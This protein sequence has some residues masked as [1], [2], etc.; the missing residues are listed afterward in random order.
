MVRTKGKKACVTAPFQRGCVEVR[1]A[2]QNNLKGV[3]VDLPLGKLTVVTGP[4]GSGKSSLAFETIYAE[5]Q[6]RYVETFSPYMRQFLDRMDKPR[7]DDIRGIPPAIAIE[8][9]NPVKTSRSTVGTMTEINDYLKLLW[10]RIAKA[11]CPNCGREIRSETAKSIADEVFSLFEAGGDSPNGRQAPLRPGPIGVNRPDRATDGENIV[12]IT[13]WVAV[14]PKTD[15]KQFFDFLQQQ[16]YLRVWIDGEVIRVDDDPKKITRLGARVQVI[17]D[18]ITIT[19]ENRARL[20]EALE[21]ALRFG[22]GKVNVIRIADRGVRSA[23][24]PKAKAGD[25]RQSGIGNPHSE[26]PFST[27]WHCA[28][29]DI[30]IRPPSPGLFSFNNPL[31]ACPEC[32]GFGRTITIDLNKAIPD[33]SLSIKQGAV[34]VFR[35]QEFGESQK[36]LLRACAREEVDINV[37]FEELPKSDQEFVINGEK[38]VVAARERGESYSDDDYDDDRWYGVR[39]FFRWA[40]SQVYKM[41]MRVLL[42]R[43]RSYTTCPKCNGGRFQPETLNYEIVAGRKSAGR[44]PQSEI[45]FTL[46]DFQALSINNARDVL[47]AVEIAANDS[48]AEMLRREIC[49][50]L[51]YLCEVGV[52]YLTLDRSTRTLSG[53][54]V[55]R[56]NLTTCLG[57][58]LVNT[59]FVMDEPSIGLHPRD[60]GRLVRVMHNLRDR[61]NTLLVV[62]H[63]E[64][65]IR[66]AD[67]L[68]D[69]GPGRGERG[70]ELIYSGPLDQLLF[71]DKSLTADYLNGRKSISVPKK[72]RKSSSSV[73]IIGA[74]EHNL[75]KI[76]VDI[77][78]G[79]FTC[80]TGVSGSGKSTLIHDVLYRNLLAAKGQSSDQEAGAC[81]SITGLH[82]INEVVMVD[83][84]ALARTPRSTPIL[85]LGLYDRVRELFA[86]QPEALSQGLTASAFSFNSGSGRC[87]R[88]SGTGYEK[89]EMQF[90]SD[91]YVRCAECEGKRFQPHVL[92]IKLH[93]KSIHDVL[94]LTVH[95]AIQFFAQIGEIKTLSEP[96]DVLDEVGLGYLRLGQPLNTLSGGESQRLKLVRHLSENTEHRNGQEIRDAVASAKADPQSAIGNL[97]IFD[98]PTTGLHFDDVAMLLQVFQRLVDAGHSLVVIEH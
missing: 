41:H 4:S 1:G 56:V 46:P 21:T 78:L 91:L 42:S 93:G 92:K 62:E 80:V 35:G 52:G 89:I 72:R 14:P 29:C 15:P 11:F 84:S 6:R 49:A 37:P 63:E 81:R 90:L 50:R 33:R 73:K 26:M 28:H 31:G 60:V 34:R 22:K 82:R 83:Q 8:Q 53:G 32:R 76:D 95:E 79:V 94:E 9:S 13:F 70:G 38:S 40:E 17:Q 12:L 18:R 2:R 27:G 68:I 67:N 85:Y 74:R 48:T 87:E 5:G 23:D 16:G 7:V 69:I 57:A 64:Q 47:G 65:I 86:R 58:S 43:Y 75:K 55:Q 10:P 25:G 36:D 71:K 66:A 59:L 44:S 98:E 39:G 51:S 77:P 19:T 24:R 88:C 45:Q 96:L 3:D 54:E 20:V 97:F 30:D 61:G